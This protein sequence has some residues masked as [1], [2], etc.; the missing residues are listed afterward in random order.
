[1]GQLWIIPWN[2]ETASPMG[3]LEEVAAG[4]FLRHAPGSGSHAAA[5]YHH[6]P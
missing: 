3:G 4:R 6:T 2:K 5:V 1:M